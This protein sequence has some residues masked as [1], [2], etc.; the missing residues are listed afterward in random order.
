MYYVYILLQNNGQHYVGSTPDLKNRVSEHERGYAESTK[1]LR[2]LKLVWYCGFE[3]RLAALR[4]EKYLKGGSGTAFRH[5]H[6]E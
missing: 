6:L 4:F 1:N 2:P 5:K 3:D